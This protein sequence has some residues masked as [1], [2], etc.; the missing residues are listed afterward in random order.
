MQSN[1]NGNLEII[2]NQI[3]KS[4]E[5]LERLYNALE[6]G[7][8]DLDILAPRIKMANCELESLEKTKY[9]LNIKNSVKP[10]KEINKQTIINYL[11][12]F[13]NLMLKGSLQEKREFIKSFINTITINL[14][15]IEIEY[16]FPINKKAE[17]SS[18]EVLPTD[19]F[20]GDGGSRTRVR[21]K[22]TT[23]FSILSPLLIFP[24]RTLRTG[25]VPGIP[26]RVGSPLIRKDSGLPLPES[27][28]FATPG[29]VEVA[30]TDS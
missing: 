24:V 7:K 22:V 9:D 28:P 4:N 1:S 20:S 23:G 2:I 21:N 26:E 10:I 12:D 3:G 30:T 17:F 18:S 19:Q 15:N 16:K 5:K 25:N 29:R 8:L 14:P 13:N 11:K 27:T 6:T